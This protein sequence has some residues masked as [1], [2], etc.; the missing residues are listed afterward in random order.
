MQEDDVFSFVFTG[1]Y[2]CKAKFTKQIL[3]DRTGIQEEHGYFILQVKTEEKK[4]T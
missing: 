3:S 4:V 1:L 2:V